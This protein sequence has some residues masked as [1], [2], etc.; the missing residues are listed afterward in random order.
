MGVVVRSVEIFINRMSMPRRC[1]EACG[2][3][4]EL[5]ILDP[6]YQSHSFVAFVQL[7]YPQQLCSQQIHTT[8]WI[9]IARL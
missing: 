4:K 5:A 7:E 6:V 8:K 1:A 3:T 2:L 9:R